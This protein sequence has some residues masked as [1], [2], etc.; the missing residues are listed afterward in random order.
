MV[1]KKGHAKITDFGLAKIA[2]STR[3][4][5][6]GI[7]VG[8]VA[9]MSPEQARGEGLDHRSDIWSLGVLRGLDYAWGTDFSKETAQLGIQMFERAVELDPEFALSYAEL[10]RAHSFMH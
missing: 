10:S 4:T 3:V 5:R 8:T 7:T 9:Y 1:T 2:G 6:T